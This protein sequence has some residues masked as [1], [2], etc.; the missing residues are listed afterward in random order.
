MKFTEDEKEE[1]QK[2]QN[3]DRIHKWWKYPKRAR[4]IAFFAGLGGLIIGIVIPFAVFENSNTI[5]GG[6]VFKDF[7]FEHATCDQLDKLFDLE[8]LGHY[9]RTKMMSKYM[10]DCT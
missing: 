6:E 2:Q 4:D 7:I 3:D 5:V 1:I 8:D 10:V 9:F